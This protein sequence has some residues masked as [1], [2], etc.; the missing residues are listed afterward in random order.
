MRDQTYR[1]RNQLAETAFSRLA[2]EREWEALDR[3]RFGGSSHAA[4]LSDLEMMSDRQLV[5]AYLDREE[6]QRAYADD[7][8]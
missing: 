8:R 6:L 2:S 4:D 1:V 7:H 5:N 3:A